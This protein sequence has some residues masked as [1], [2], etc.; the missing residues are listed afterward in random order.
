[1][2]D[3]R[4]AGDTRSMEEV[5]EIME[6]ARKEVEGGEARGVDV[7][8]LP[9]A[10]FKK[11]V[12]EEGTSDPSKYLRFL[13]GEGKIEHTREALGNDNELVNPNET[14][15]KWKTMEDYA[16]ETKGRPWEEIEWDET[17]VE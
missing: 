1:V 11:T 5:R 2:E 12:L 9:L 7:E 10:E 15:W 16:R 4:I 6:R 8:E 14:L 3:V 13:M 17:K